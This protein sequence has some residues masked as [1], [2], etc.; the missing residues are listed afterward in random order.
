MHSRN[1]RPESPGTP[2]RV[3]LYRAFNQPI[4][5]AS[6][7]SALF[8]DLINRSSLTI[9][10]D[11]GRSLL[12]TVLASSAKAVTSTLGHRAMSKVSVLGRLTTQIAVNPSWTHNPF[13]WKSL[14]HD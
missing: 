9:V 14:V 11:R 7:N 5:D 10:L 13:A 12:I 1:Q 6:I 2:I 8:L 4:E 3:W